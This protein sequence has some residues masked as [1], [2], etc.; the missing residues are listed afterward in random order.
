MVLQAVTPLT[1]ECYYDMISSAL[2]I[3]RDKSHGIKLDAFCHLP[4]VLVGTVPMSWTAVSIVRKK[5]FGD[6]RKIRPPTLFRSTI[7]VAKALYVDLMSCPS[8]P[9]PFLYTCCCWYM[10]RMKIVLEL[11]Q[12]AKCLK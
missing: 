5:Q 1:W 3:S 10:K 9:R 6:M 4:L 2:P 7:Y 12:V 11:L 8:Q